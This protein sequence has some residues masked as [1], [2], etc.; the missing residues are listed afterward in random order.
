[1]STPAPQT[2]PTRTPTSQIHPQQLQ[3]QQPTPSLPIDTPLKPPPA[4]TVTLNDLDSPE[5]KAPIFISTV[6]PPTRSNTVLTGSI[7]SGSA[8]GSGALVGDLGGLGSSSLNN[9][10]TSPLSVSSDRSTAS[11][12]PSQTATLRATTRGPRTPQDFKYG[13]VLGEGSYSTVVEAWDLLSD[14]KTA[15]QAAAIAAGGGTLSASSSYASLRNNNRSRASS[16]ASIGAA[17]AAAAAGLSSPS[18]A[19]TNGHLSSSVGGND[20]LY[21]RSPES[22]ASAIV[23]ENSAIDTTGKRVYAI[24]ILHKA[25][26]IKE[27]KHKYVGFEK[28]ALSRLTRAPGIITLYWT[29][30]DRESLYFVLALAPNGELLSH[31]KTL[32]S[33]STSCIRYY[34]A[35]LLDAIR[36]IHEAGIIHRDMKPEN[37]LFDKE[38]RIKVTDFG[39]AKILMPSAAALA[40][41]A[42]AAASTPSAVTVPAPVTPQRQQQQREVR[43]TT[44]TPRSPSTSTTMRPALVRSADEADPAATNGNPSAILPGSAVSPTEKPSSFVGTAEYVSPELLLSRQV[45]FASDW[46]AFGCIVFQMLC[47]RP[48]FK[49]PTEYQTFQ[50]ILHREMEWPEV[51]EGEEDGGGDVAEIR[52]LVEGL[53]V[54]APEDRLGYVPLSK[55]AGDDDIK[56]E[57]EEDEEVKARRIVQAASEG[58]RQIRSQA[59]FKDVE[60]DLL[61]NGPVPKLE[62]GRVGP[63]VPMGT[64]MSQLEYEFGDAAFFEEDEE[65]GDGEEDED[66]DEVVEVMASGRTMAAQT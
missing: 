22:A 40:N 54:L 44:M 66:E 11:A 35:Q 65:D 24:K 3:Q 41:R 36:S 49:G 2:I 10:G 1:M 60:W 61:W 27:K 23:K 16:T 33:F 53:L 63:R 25:H 32:G 7:G 55:K 13:Q 45:S 48:P 5:T 8:G 18:S 19:R 20:N 59:F 9:L 34:S 42:A 29:F 57:K 30:Q 64:P 21:A 52:A 43:T 56:P 51:F 39:S 6:S 50:R 62:A 14:P 12:P 58:A 15:A 4:T 28:E 37:V 31:I 26:I 17:A 47:G 46:W 38:M